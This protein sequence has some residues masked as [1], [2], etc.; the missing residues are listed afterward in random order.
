MTPTRYWEDFK[1]YYHWAEQLELRNRGLPYDNV[2]ADPLMLT[3]P[4]Y[5]T[6]HRRYAGFSKVLEHLHGRRPKSKSPIP[7][8]GGYDF[9]T[10]TWHYV[11][12]VHR[13]TGS[14]ASFE[15]DHGYRNTIVLEMADRGDLKDMVNFVHYVGNSDRPIFT[16]LGNQIPPFNK[17]TSP[18]FKLGGIEYLCTFAPKLAVDYDRW[19]N[20]QSDRV[21][22]QRAVDWVL[23]WQTR[24]GLKRY[25]FVLTAFVMDTAEYMPVYVNPRS[26]CYYGKNCLEALDLMFEHTGRGKYDEIMERIGH[27]FPGSTYYDLEDVSCDAIRYWENFVPKSYRKESRERLL[28]QSM[29]QDHPNR[30]GYGWSP[31]E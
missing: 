8:Q 18:L 25:A 19:L 22:I 30:F 21:G 28:N 26:H 23:D 6:V 14:A 3:V 4:I 5:D 12:L 13:I 11:H 2:V 7:Y 29:I 24:H 16:S 10:A 27:E 9:P 1:R 31:L 20:D 15:P 17:P